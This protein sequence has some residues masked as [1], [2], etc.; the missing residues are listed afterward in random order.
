MHKIWLNKTSLILCGIY[1]S[2]AALLLLAMLLS[3]DHKGAYV[4]GQLAGF[5]ILA[6]L[7]WTGTID[8]VMRNWPWLNNYPAVVS[9]SVMLCYAIG[10]GVGLL[11]RAY[12]KE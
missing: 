7:S 11:G 1:L 8:F 3:T 12:S 5:P 9:L 2:V 4:W 10:V 6:L